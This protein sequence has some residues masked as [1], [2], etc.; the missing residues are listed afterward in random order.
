MPLAPRKKMDKGKEE[1]ERERRRVKERQNIYGFEP[2]EV[3]EV[4]HDVPVE[5]KEIGLHGQIDTVVIL[6]SGEVFPVDVKYSDF[7]AVRRN[8]KKQLVGYSILLERHFNRR[9]DCGILYFPSQKRSIRVPISPEDKESLL[10]DVQ[11]IRGLLK[12]EAMPRGARK[13][14]CRYCEVAKYCRV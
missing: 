10:K 14:M 4:M 1:H 5:Y 12:S 3:R 8:W 2:S 13:E 9:V 7:G 6:S 11:R